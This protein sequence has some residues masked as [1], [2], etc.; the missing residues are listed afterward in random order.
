MNTVSTYKSLFRE[1]DSEGAKT[2]SVSRLMLLSGYHSGGIIVD[3][4]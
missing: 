4:T 1:E 3:F 2:P